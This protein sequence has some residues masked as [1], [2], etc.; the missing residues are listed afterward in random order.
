MTMINTVLDQVARCDRAELNK[1]IEAVKLRQTALARTATRS[2]TVG[3]T[4]QFTVGDTVQFTGKG[5]RTVVGTVRKVN[6]KTVLVD[7]PTQGRWKVTASML[8][9]LAA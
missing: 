6:I 1:V 2:F 8:T 5:G 9:A 7:S 4:V 3:D